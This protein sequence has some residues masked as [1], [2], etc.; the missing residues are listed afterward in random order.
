M[1]HDYRCS[2]LI[3]IGLLR[4]PSLLCPFVPLLCTLRQ[5]LDDLPREQALRLSGPLFPLPT[6]RC[7]TRWQSLTTIS[8][9]F[10]SLEMV[11]SLKKIENELWSLFIKLV[12]WGPKGLIKRLEQFYGLVHHKPQNCNNLILHI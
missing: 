2:D 8:L 10:S 11:K 1:F 3:L 4:K 12:S 9:S 6:T 5:R 7:K